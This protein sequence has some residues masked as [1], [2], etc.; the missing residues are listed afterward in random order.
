[1]N[2][3]DWSK[4]LGKLGEIVSQLKI[5]ETTGS[6]NTDLVAQGAQLPDLSVLVTDF[7][8]AGKGRAGRDWQAPAKSSLFASVLL[9]PT[10]FGPTSFSWLPLMAGLAISRA[11]HRFGVEQ[12]A[13]KWPNDV[14]VGDR[15]LSGVLSELLSNLSGVVIGSGVNLTQSQSELPIAA[16]TSMAIEAHSQVGRDDF[17]Q[18]YL[19]ELVS[20]YHD[21]ETAAGDPNQSGLRQSVIENC[22]SIGREVR[23]ILPGDKEEFGRAIDI[24]DTGRLIVDLGDQKGKLAVAA[25]DIV[26]LRHNSL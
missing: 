14:L 3:T 12:A 10:S 5:V 24:D 6:T 1:M 17:L 15:K 2:S 22:S 20:L 21:F 4:P 13:V 9:K 25:A 16:A 11:A 18:A 8:S 23:V 26:H 7:Q 19:E